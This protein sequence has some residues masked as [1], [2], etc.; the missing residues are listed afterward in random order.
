LIRQGAINSNYALGTGGSLGRN[1]FT[2][3]YGRSLNLSLAKTTRFSENT[4]LE[5]RFDM[6]NVTRE[7][8]HRTNLLTSVRGSN[9]L[10]TASTLGSIAGRNTFFAPHIIQIGVRLAF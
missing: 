9:T 10:T 7:V 6:F 1:V 5:L 4:R 8:L 2:L 3:P